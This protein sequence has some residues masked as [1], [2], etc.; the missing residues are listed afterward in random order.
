MDAQEII[1]RTT[2]EQAEAS[3]AH[4]DPLPRIEREGPS[5]RGSS[6]T[7]KMI[8]FITRIS[9]NIIHGNYCVNI[10]THKSDMAATLLLCI[11]VIYSLCEGIPAQHQCCKLTL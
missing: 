10:L 11:A 3:L 7:R 9:F 2:F 8:S 5:G 6:Q 1:S 4:Y